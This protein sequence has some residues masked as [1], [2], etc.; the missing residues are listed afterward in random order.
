MNKYI[1]YVLEIHQIQIE[2]DAL[3]EFDAVD[4]AASGNGRW[5]DNSMEFVDSVDS[6]EWIAELIEEYEG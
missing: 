2:V 5:I 6:D 4:Q 1:V 3:D